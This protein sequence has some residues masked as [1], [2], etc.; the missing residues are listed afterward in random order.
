VDE[1]GWSIEESCA[2][3]KALMAEGVDVI[4]CSSGGIATP[5]A[6]DSGPVL[7]LGYQVPYAETVR[8]QTG[9]KTMAVGLIIHPKQ[10]EAI[11]QNGQAD[12]VA[13]G[14]EFLYN[15]QWPLHAAV[16]LGVDRPYGLLPQ[17][18]SYWLE[19]RAERDYR[20]V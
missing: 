18:Y 13:L 2:L 1:A 8:K 12:L 7:K 19:K 15:P 5:S 11:L 17:N 6:V 9:A 3:A 14:R 4:D 10:A 20:N 16:E